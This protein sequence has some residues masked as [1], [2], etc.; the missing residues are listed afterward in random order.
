MNENIKSI[1]MVTGG[2]LISLF[3]SIVRSLCLPFFMSVLDYGYFQSYTFYITLFPI[4][5]LGYNDGIYLRYGKYNYNELPFNLLSGSNRIFLTAS[6]FLSLLSIIIAKV[7]FKDENLFFAFVFSASYAVFLCLNGLMLQVFQI[8]KQ[9]KKYSTY[10][11][12]GRLLSTTL[13]II[14][15]LLGHRN[16]IEIIIVDLTC[17]AI[18]NIVIL[19]NNKA[20]FFS[21]S[22]R[23][24]SVK[25]YIENIKVGYSLLIAG[26]IGILFLG[27]GRLIVQFFGDVIQFSIYSF[28]ISIATF[29]SVAISSASL[30]VYPIL[31]RYSL[32]ELQETY[33][34]IN[35]K[36]RVMIIP[37]I[38]SYFLLMVLIKR[39]YPQYIGALEFLDIIVITM[40]IQSFMYV[41]QNTYYKVLRIE[42]ELMIDNLIS[43]SI[44][45]IIGLP[46]YYFTGKLATV[47][48]STLLAQLVR[49]SLSYC[50]IRK[51]LGVSLNYNLTEFIIIIVFLFLSSL[52]FVDSIVEITVLVFI[53]LFYINHNMDVF[54]SFLL[55]R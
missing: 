9:F 35:S 42:R 54:K 4:I 51:S 23:M 20:L 10:T 22:D 7:L 41:L 28:A 48:L 55:K 6:L 37:I 24:G 18:I 8:T 47:A 44:V 15:L 25:E 33:M 31:A 16:Y 34:G 26:L 11:V 39:F 3:I 12:L 2:Q 53:S 13:I 36:I 38:F 40:Y 30:V 1:L 46:L 43:I 32:P 17:F 45:F 27:G 14:L 50:R 5:A 49:Y 52:K 21:R 19:F 29:I